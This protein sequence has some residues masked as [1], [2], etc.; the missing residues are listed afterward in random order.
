[1]GTATFKRETANENNILIV[2][3]TSPEDMPYLNK[4]GALVTKIG[5]MTSHPAVVCRQLNKPCIVGASYLNFEYKR[6][7]TNEKNYYA[8]N[9][10]YKGDKQI[11]EGDEITIIGDTGDLY[12][13]RCEVKSKQLFVDE[14]NEILNHE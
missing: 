13:G 4:I 9:F 12:E 2:D 10:K 8:V 7:V 5:G 14:V 11:C 3:S 1:M 6:D